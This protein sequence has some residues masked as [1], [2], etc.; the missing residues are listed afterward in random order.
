MDLGTNPIPLHPLFPK[1]QFNSVQLPTGPPR[2]P[3]TATPGVFAGLHS[4]HTFGMC[5][6]KAEVTSK[7]QTESKRVQILG[8]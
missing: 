6:P 7:A 3:E 2:H 1:M 8:T 4:R 5:P